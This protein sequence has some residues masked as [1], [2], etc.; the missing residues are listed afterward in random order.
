MGASIPSAERRASRSPTAAEVSR[1]PA[2]GN[3]A[4]RAIRSTFRARLMKCPQITGGRSFAAGGCWLQRT[5]ERD[6]VVECRT[7]HRLGFRVPV[8]A[9]H[10]PQVAGPAVVEPA[11]ALADAKQRRRVEPRHAGLVAKADVVR[12]F[13]RVL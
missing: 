5:Q 11:L 12:A 1:R 9:E 3:I 2:G 6:E 8:F 7:L 10:L 13:R 4:F